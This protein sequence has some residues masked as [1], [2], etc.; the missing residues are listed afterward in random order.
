MKKV[1]ITGACGFIGSHLVEYFVAKKIKVIAYDKYNFSADTGWLENNKNIRNTK[2]VLGDINDYSLTNKLI[3]EVDY[4]I[5]LAALISIPYSYFSPG[6]Y[7]K[8]NVEGTYNILESAR[9]N[10]KKV[11]I[12]STSEVYGTGIKFPMNENHPLFAQSP[13]AA[14]K[15]AADNL[16]LS[17]YNTFNL[18]VKIIRP[19]NAFGP[20]QSNRAIIPTV[21]SQIL[22]NRK[23]I[24]V[25]NIYP[26]RDW[27]Y[28]TDLCSAFYSLYKSPR[29]FGK[30]YNVGTGKCYSVSDLLKISQNICKTKKKILLENQRKRPTRSEVKKLLCD[31]RLFKKDIGW[32]S[33]INFKKGLS[34][35]INWFKK[36]LNNKKSHIYQI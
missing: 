18:P 12:T 34:L 25:G 6:S 23:K 16:T 1:L 19:F 31:P 22:S 36:N 20:R 3:K 10:R 4:V 9:L 26:K 29:G 24:K 13:Y 33:K 5:H 32:K 30:I 17:Y 15:I 11:I 35:T 14:S 7:V 8:T 28:V 21:I 2:I 27:T